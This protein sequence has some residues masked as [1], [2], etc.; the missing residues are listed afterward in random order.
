LSGG[1]RLRSAVVSYHLASTAGGCLADFSLT[2]SCLCELVVVVLAVAA[3]DSSL[4]A[5]EMHRVGFSSRLYRRSVRYVV[6]S[7]TH[8]DPYVVAREWPSRGPAGGH[9]AKMMHV[10]GH[11]LRPPRTCLLVG[12]CCPRRL[13]GRLRCSDGCTPSRRIGRR[14]VPGR[15][16]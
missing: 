2:R 11:R 8:D 1:H 3:H 7:V 9:L 13:L 15:L 4:T 16:A 6:A 12:R 5:W 14:L 10:V